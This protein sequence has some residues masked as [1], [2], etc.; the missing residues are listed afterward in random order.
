MKKIISTG[1]I[2]GA[3]MLIASLAV[4]WIFGYFFPGVKAEYENT[5]LFRPWS[6]PKMSLYFLHPFL[7]AFLLA[8]FW[9]KTKIVFKN[10]VNFGVFYWIIASIPGMFISYSSF[11]VSFLMILEWTLAGLIQAI[12]AGL[13]LEKMNGK[14]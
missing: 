1:L 6:D 5:G 2:V 12:L 13:V 10:G 4:S 7:A 9:D 14:A 3:I 8:W 11:Q